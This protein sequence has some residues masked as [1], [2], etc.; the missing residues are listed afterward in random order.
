MMK[1]AKAYLTTQV[2]TTT[3]GDLLLMLYDAAIKFLKQAKIKVAERN[4]AQKGILISR[5]ID[6][7]SELAESLNKEKGGDLARNLNNLYFYCSTRLAKANLKMDPALIDEVIGIL[8]GLRSAFAQIIP[9]HE[10]R[11]ASALHGASPA[12]E[13]ETPRPVVPPKPPQ[14]NRLDLMGAPAVPLPGALP[15]EAPAPKPAERPATAQAQA[16]PA[17]APAQSRQAAQPG[18]SVSRLRAANAYSANRN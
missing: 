2:T 7:I 5:A 13:P 14:I 10:G 12:T 16:R 3:Q 18:G 11:P 1:G 4:F 6:I 8:S 15:E 17:P 9:Q